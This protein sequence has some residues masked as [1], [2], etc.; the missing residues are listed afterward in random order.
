MLI[1]HVDARVTTGDISALK[2]ETVAIR[3]AYADS[4]GVLLIDFF[5][6]EPARH[7]RIIEIYRDSAALLDYVKGAPLGLAEMIHIESTTVY[8]TPSEEAVELIRSFGNATVRTP[9]QDDTGFR[10]GY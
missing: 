7:L 9:I 5:L 10:A 6:D 3:R 4:N 2:R 8:G 1:F